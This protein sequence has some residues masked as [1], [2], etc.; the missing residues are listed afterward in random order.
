MPM[1]RV[2]RMK[3]MSYYLYK[4]VIQETSNWDEAD[5]MNWEVTSKEHMHTEKS[6]Q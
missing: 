5:E 2:V 3:I 1:S 6:N 4:E